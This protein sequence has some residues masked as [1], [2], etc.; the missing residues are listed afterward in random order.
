MATGIAMQAVAA[1]PTDPDPLAGGPRRCRFTKRCDRSDN[2]M[3]RHTRIGQAG[4][5]SLLGDHIAAA[6]AASLDLDQ[7]FPGARHRNGPVDPFELTAGKW[8]LDDLHHG[9]SSPPAGRRLVTAQEA[10][11][12]GRG[13]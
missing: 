7:H 11:G 3:P 2:L 8:N 9:H 10:P 13:P 4:K 1:V 5:G 6:D 12:S